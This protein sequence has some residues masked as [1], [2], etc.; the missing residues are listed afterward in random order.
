MLQ[1][2][3]TACHPLLP[4]FG[5]SGEAH[6]SLASPPFLVDAPLNLGSAATLR[7]CHVILTEGQRSRARRLRHLFDRI[8][9][10]IGR[11]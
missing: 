3:Y 2:V 9:L 8:P 10:L 1:K 11:V 4:C 5:S 7:D 6:Q